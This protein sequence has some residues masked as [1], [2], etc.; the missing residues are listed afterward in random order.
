MTDLEK[1]EEQ[2]DE[3]NEEYSCMRSGLDHIRDERDRY[4][5]MVDVLLDVIVLLKGKINMP[6]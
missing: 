5:K 6:F 2:Y 1:L 3:L 4:A